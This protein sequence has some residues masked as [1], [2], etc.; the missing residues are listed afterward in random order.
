MWLLASTSSGSVGVGVSTEL[1]NTPDNLLCSQMAK[2]I[3]EIT[4][5]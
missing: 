1:T 2:G 5:R 3:T 4:E